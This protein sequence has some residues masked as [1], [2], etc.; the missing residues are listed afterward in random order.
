M[1]PR[2]IT[3][4]SFLAVLSLLFLLTATAS[5]AETLNYMG[6]SVILNSFFK[7][8]SKA[9]TAQSGIPVINKAQMTGQGI[10]GLLNNQCNIAG[11]GRALKADEKSRGLV[12]TAIA[13]NLVAIFVHKSNPVTNLT[14][15]QAKDI[16]AGKIT[17]WK[18]VGGADLPILLVLDSPKSQHRKHFTKEIMGDTAMSTKAFS[19]PKPPQSVGKV[20]NFP[21]AI[22]YMS[23]GIIK[24][25]PKVKALSLDGVQP[26]PENIS[27]G[28]YK[29]VMNMYLFTKGAPTGAPKQMIDFLHS[30]KGKE[31]IIAGGMLGM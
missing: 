5:G 15:E 22:A 12:E 3:K 31:I 6:S 4:K 29:I 8:A 2:K 28:T 20:A 19:V 16:F 26:N 7:D 14:S 1:A 24:R 27:N 13:K 30:P 11:G 21:P 17:N 10:L 25:N 9:F 23:L 18:D